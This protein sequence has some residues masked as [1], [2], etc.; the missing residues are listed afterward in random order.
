MA[1]YDVLRAIEFVRADSELQLGERPIHLFGTGRGAFRGYLA[2]ALDPTVIALELEAPVPDL[3][4]MMTQRLYARP[5][6]L[7]MLPDYLFPGL[8]ESFDWRDVAPLV[9]GR[10]TSAEVMR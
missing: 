8:L 4:E 1:V 3:D 5:E 10:L 6:Q 7:E 2:A 9:A